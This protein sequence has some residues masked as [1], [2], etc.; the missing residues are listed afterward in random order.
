MN[1]LMR[2]SQSQR[3]LLKKEKLMSSSGASVIWRGNW[4]ENTDARKPHVF[5]SVER[6]RLIAGSPVG[7]INLPVRVWSFLF[8]YFSNIPVTY[9]HWIRC[10]TTA[11]RWRRFL[12]RSLPLYSNTVEHLW[13]LPVR[14]IQDSPS[15]PERFHLS[16][17]S[18]M[19]TNTCM[20]VFS[21]LL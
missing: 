11:D 7:W 17:L 3:D 6:R 19:K 21:C 1:L 20:L 12:P 14:W 2:R 16:V 13:D 8:L 9:F 15:G 4:P 5:F 18:F 10:T